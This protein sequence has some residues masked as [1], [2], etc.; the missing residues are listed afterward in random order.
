MIKTASA[1]LQCAISEMADLEV[2]VFANQLIKKGIAQSE[3]EYHKPGNGYSAPVDDVDLGLTTAADREGLPVEQ[4][5]P[6]TSFLSHAAELDSDAAVILRGCGWALKSLER[7][8]GIRGRR[9]G[10]TWDCWV[11]KVR[12]ICKDHQ[13]PVKVAKHGRISPFVR[14]I[15]AL[16]KLFP[17]GTPSIDLTRGLP[18]LAGA[19]YRALHPKAAPRITKSRSR[20]IR[21]TKIVPA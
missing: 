1:T 11:S 17:A 16:E 9:E 14:F 3:P 12:D 18:A 21:D 6:L 4:T 10:E 13:L 5:D 20:E 7:K 15:R 19:I 2:G 8:N